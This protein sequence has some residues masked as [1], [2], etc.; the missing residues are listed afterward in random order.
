MNPNHVTLLPNARDRL[1][2]EFVGSH[3]RFVKAGV[4]LDRVNV[5]EERPQ[6]AVGESYTVVCTQHTRQTARHGT[7]RVSQ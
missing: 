6:N 2:E 7:R 3:V 4:E 1:R 5:V